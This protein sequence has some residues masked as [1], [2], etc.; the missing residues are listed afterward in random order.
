MR[1]SAPAALPPPHAPAPPRDPSW[2]DAGRGHAGRGG[3]GGE[4]VPVGRANGVAVFRLAEERSRLEAEER[5]IAAERD[6]LRA[7][8]PAGEV[9]AEV[10][11]PAD[12]LAREREREQ[13]R[14]A[15]RLK[16]Y[17]DRIGRQ[18]TAGKSV[19]QDAAAR[20]RTEAEARALAGE[21]RRAAELAEV[22][23]AER[24][25]ERGG[26]RQHAP[27]PLAHAGSGRG[28]TGGDGGSLMGGFVS[29]WWSG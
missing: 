28:D 15:A 22:Q 8:K 13:A 2:G 19:R 12:L 11:R 29:R 4:V 1:P 7:P 6:E 5:R 14:E 24:A 20:L 3:S 23:A 16:E 21:Q 9:E 18:R 27:A 10:A 26:A 17:E 25:L